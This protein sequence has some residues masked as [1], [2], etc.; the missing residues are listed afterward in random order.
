MSVQQQGAQLIASERI[1]FR[2]VIV[3]PA[4]VVKVA[5]A[6]ISFFSSVVFGSNLSE[7]LKNW[8]AVERVQWHPGIRHEPTPPAW[9]NYG[10]FR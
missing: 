6:V 7:V 2:P 10:G 8:A 4:V 9:H 5:K 3:I 1:E